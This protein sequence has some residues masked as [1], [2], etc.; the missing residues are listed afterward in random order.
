MRAFKRLGILLLF[1]VLFVTGTAFASESLE[2]Y[3]VEITANCWTE[4]VSIGGSTLYVPY[5]KASITNNTSEAVSKIKVQ[6]VFYDDTEKS[7]WSDES[8]NLV[9][10]SD[11][12]LRPSYS[13]TAFVKSS[14]GYT[15]K[16]N[17]KNLPQVFAE[18]YVNGILYGR[19][20]IEKTFKEKSGSYFLSEG[21]TQIEDEEISFDTNDPFGLMVTASYWGTNTGLTGQTLYVPYIK[22]KVTNQEIDPAKKITVKAVFINEEDQSVFSDATSYLI[23]S[24]DTPLKRG[25]NK[26]AYLRSSVGYKKQIS[27]SS[28]PDISAEIYVNDEYYGKV[29]IKKTYSAEMLDISLSRA[30]NVIEDSSMQVDETNPYLVTI[31]ANCWTLETGFGGSTLYVPYLKLNVLNQ[32]GKSV[33]KMNVKVVF[34]DVNE[35]EVWSD[36]SSTLVSSTDFPLRHGYSKTAYIKGTVGYRKQ[37]SESSLPTITAEVYLNDKLMGETTIKKTYIESAISELLDNKV[38]IGIERVEKDKGKAPF[39]VAVTTN[40]WAE[41]SGASTLYTPYLKLKVINQQGKPAEKATVKVVFYNMSEKTLWSDETEYLISSSDTPVKD[42]YG[43]TAFVRSSVGYTSKIPEVRLPKITAEVYINDDLYGEVEIV[44]TYSESTIMVPLEKKSPEE[45]KDAE[46]NYA[47]KD[48]KA[49]SITYSSNCWTES[50]GLNGQILYVPYL[51][52]NVT[53][54]MST[55]A[56]RIVLHVVFTNETDKSVWS[57]ETDYLV[58]GSDT[59][60]KSG[61]NKTAF[62]KSSV[63]YKSKLSIN[64]LPSITA[65]VYINDE[66]YDTVTIENT[67]GN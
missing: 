18:V 37:I 58:S 28:L 41:N 61:F 38:K 25:Y 56:D 29:G 7:I 19:I 60:L 55:A 16:P 43:K 24:G 39:A 46:N 12:L 59:A 49:Y 6:V 67:Y 5:I 3:K 57:D 36:T 27:I 64:Q 32:S 22:L 10:S 40:C 53:N 42:G 66:L 50:K 9:S 14:V 13:K 65:E 52:I 45:H 26:T 17:E 54:Q 47:S 21:Y 1:A 44:N 35:M 48:G 23:S 30:N 33:D 51:K 8:T 63:G 15:S 4:N 31:V 62:I 34:Y 20:G 2:D 11:D